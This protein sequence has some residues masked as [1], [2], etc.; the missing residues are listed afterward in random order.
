MPTLKELYSDK[1][2]SQVSEQTKTDIIS[3]IGIDINEA[4][5][6]VV[7]SRFTQSELTQALHYLLA[8]EAK[9]SPQVQ[10]LVIRE[11]SQPSYISTNNAFYFRND[12]PFLWYWM[13]Y[14]SG[15]SNASASS[16]SSS[17]DC[18]DCKGDGEGLLIAL[19]A[20]CVCAAG[21]CCVLCMKE[22]IEGPESDCVIN[23]KVGVSS[24]TG[25]A[26]F[27]SLL[28]YLIQE[29]IWRASLVDDHNWDVHGYKLFLVLIAASTGLFAS[30]AVSTVNNIWRC[31]PEPTRGL[32]QPS[33]AVLEALKSLETVQTLLSRGWSH[34]GD[35]IA[36]CDAFTREVVLTYIQTIACDN[37]A[38]LAVDGS[39]SSS[40]AY[41][42]NRLFGAAP[43]AVRMPEASA[44]AANLLSEPL[45]DNADAPRFDPSHL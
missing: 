40:S 18:G 3:T 14:N 5:S 13:G 35:N 2:F 23:T 37:D 31:L 6:E 28:C 4:K 8:R 30:G 26:V 7:A 27:I 45:L 41:R 22:T 11:H 29:D 39:A 34:E 44:P 42:F 36:E 32:P 21:C 12:D 9:N 16:S 33:A 25:V 38:R 10:R 1:R 19:A 15:Y 24:V 17:M 43:A 20:A